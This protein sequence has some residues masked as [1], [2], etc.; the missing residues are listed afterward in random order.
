MERLFQRG[1]LVNSLTVHPLSPISSTH[2]RIDIGAAAFRL[3][4]FH[5]CTCTD[6][7][8]RSSA[9]F[10]R[11]RQVVGRSKPD[12]RYRP[13]QTVLLPLLWQ[14]GDPLLVKLGHLA[15]NSPATS[16]AAAPRCRSSFTTRQRS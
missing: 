6:L 9:T 14:L 12:I 10:Q 2:R 3:D 8:V 15:T 4:L 11:S 1:M 16:E 7:C 13:D 5:E